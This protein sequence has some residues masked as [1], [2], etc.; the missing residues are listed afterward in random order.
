MSMYIHF[1]CCVRYYV[2]TFMQLC[3]LECV[4]LHWYY[5]YFTI[6][7]SWFLF[8]ISAVAVADLC[9]RLGSIAHVN[10]TCYIYISGSY[11]YY[12]FHKAD[13]SINASGE[14]I[15]AVYANCSMPTRLQFWKQ[16]DRKSTYEGLRSKV[17]KFIFA[18]DRSY[19]VFCLWESELSW[20]WS[21][22]LSALR[23]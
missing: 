1:C 13:N 6:H 14:F 8:I 16:F 4:F 22:S 2:C 12:I 7:A 17:T 5:T 11:T 3:I 9:S 23:M 18:L 20:V 21:L 19:K 15:R 10:S